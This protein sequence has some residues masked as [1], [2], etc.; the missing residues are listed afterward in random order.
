MCGIIAY[1]GDREVVPLLI[2]GLKTL[3]YRGY[4]SA[5]LV[6]KQNNQLGIIKRAGRISELEKSPELG[7]L[8]G[9]IGIAHTRWATHGVPNETNAH[10][11][12]DCKKEIAIVHNGIIENYAGLREIL[13]KKGHNFISNTDS[14][15]IAHLIEDFYHGDLT[16]ATINA[17]RCIDGTFG[18]AVMSKNEDK[19]VAARRGSPLILGVGDHEMFVCSDAA[20]ILEHTKKVIYLDDNEVATITKENYSISDI[21]GNGIDKKVHE[22]KWSIDQIEKKGFKHFM[23]K[24]IFEQPDALENTLRGR[25]KDKNIKLSLNFDIK[26][27]KRIIFIACGT[28]WHSALIGKYIIEKINRIPVDVDYASE[29]RYKNPIIKEGDLVIAISQSGE[30]ADTLAAIKEAKAKKAKTMGIINVV[31]STISREVDSG[32][33]LHSGPEIGVASTK[34][35]TGQVLAILLISLYIEQEKGNK[36][37]YSLVEEITRLPEKARTIFNDTE[38]IKNIANDLRESKAFLFLGRGINFPV[39][40][41][42][43]LKLKEI[44]YIHAEGYPTAEM[45]HGPIALIEK[46]FPVIFVLNKD[47]LTKKCLS[48]IEEIKSRG[49]KIIIVTSDKEL[50]EIADKIIYVPAT[51]EELSPILNVIPLQLLSYY[52]ADLKGIDPDKPRNLAKSVTVE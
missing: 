36:I 46:D 5:G 9:S 13:K 42:G 18:L 26:S 11:H 8:N 35:F 20:G 15:V 38:K 32:I 22:I 28:S 23:L 3:E 16:E 30:T 43:A 10:P 40:L 47:N 17:L 50:K 49:G 44:S 45:K 52:I 34:A 39:A 48:N 51:K 2:K 33:Y 6:V 25:I 14:E 41:E 37:E 7:S 4:D 21:Y 31:G 1:A 29:F 27:I 24:E 12:L 19:I